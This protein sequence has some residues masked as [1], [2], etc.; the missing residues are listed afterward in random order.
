MRFQYLLRDGKSLKVAL[1]DSKSGRSYEA[2]VPQP[3]AGAWTEAFV[4]FRIPSEGEDLYADEIR[5]DADQSA[6][7]HVDDLL[8]YVPGP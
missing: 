8:L 2:E 5:L 1:T 4:D 7:L 6:E 3:A